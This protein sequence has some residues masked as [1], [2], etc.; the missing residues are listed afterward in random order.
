MFAKNTK[1]RRWLGILMVVLFGAFDAA[2][3]EAVVSYAIF[4]L[5]DAKHEGR[6]FPYIELYWQIDPGSIHYAKSAE[7][8]FFGMITTKVVFRKDTGIVKQDSYVLKTDAVDKDQLLSQ[9]ILELQRYPLTEGRVVMTLELS[10]SKGLAYTFTDTINISQEVSKPFYSDIQIM[11][12]AFS[13][14]EKGSFYKSGMQQVP[15]CMNF[16]NEER[17]IMQ[18]YCELYNLGVVDNEGNPVVHRAYISKKQFDAPVYNLSHSDT[19]KADV[20]IAFSKQFDISV[21]PSGNYYLNT[22]LEDKEKRKLAQSSVFFQ[23]SNKN[24]QKQVVTDTGFEKIT[25]FNLDKTF[26]AKYT[27]AQLKAILKMLL[28]ICDAKEKET[29]HGFLKRPDENYIRYFIY[30]F[31]SKRGDKKP[32]KA[33]DAYTEQVR[34]VNKL[35]GVSSTPG[36]ETE[37]GF[38]WLKYGKPNE[39]V[40]VENERGSLPYEVWYYNAPGTQGNP[41]VFLFYNPGFM[42]GDFKLLHSTIIGEVRNMSWRSNLYTNG[43]NQGARAEQYI[44]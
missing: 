35:F 33:W 15:M 9:K 12:T 19:I 21:L 42:V 16:I 37:R 30:N 17:K 11:D 44:R 32:D 10:E 28:P 2:A 3:I 34:E 26:V 27:M 18:Y 24:P 8:K 20:V 41:G 39:R 23:R 14:T 7:G 43:Q 5:P 36:Y 38:I 22:V 40:V 1:M 13:S 6:F 29:I 4:W 31:W 25:V